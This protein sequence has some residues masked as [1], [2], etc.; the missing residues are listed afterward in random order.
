MNAM[1][2]FTPDQFE[3]DS[4]NEDLIKMQHCPVRGQAKVALKSSRETQH[5]IRE[6]RETLLNCGFCPV[7]NQCEFQEEFNLQ[8]DMVIEEINEEWGW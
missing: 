7:V 1:D 6:L 4:N 3:S 8:I 2:S 5:A